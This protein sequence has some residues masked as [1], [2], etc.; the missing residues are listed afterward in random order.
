MAQFMV[1]YRDQFGFT[2]SC[3]VEEAK[4]ASDAI[5]KGREQL[6]E[7]FKWIYPAQYTKGLDLKMLNW[8]QGELTSEG[9]IRDKKAVQK[10]S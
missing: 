1:A 9:W 4:D 5:A 7:A 2:R 3:H 10:R 6:R 8:E